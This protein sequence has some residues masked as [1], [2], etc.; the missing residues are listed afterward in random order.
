MPNVW[1]S[2]SCVVSIVAGTNKP[3]ATVLP[4]IDN[5]LRRE[6]GSEVI[7]RA[8]SISLNLTFKFNWWQRWNRFCWILVVPQQGMFAA[9]SLR[10]FAHEADLRRRS[11]HAEQ[12]LRGP[13]CAFSV[14]D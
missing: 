5:D 10:Q 13:P 12:K 4:K 2:A 1:A 11:S 14:R 3:N 8:I 7:T 9:N 6:T